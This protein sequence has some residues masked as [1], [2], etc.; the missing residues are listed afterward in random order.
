MDR[1]T[2][3]TVI[4]WYWKGGGILGMIGALPYSLAAPDLLGD[5][6]GR[7]LRALG[8]PSLFVMAFVASFVCYLFG[9]GILTGRARARVAALIYCVVG[10]VVGTLVWART[11]PGDPLVWVNLVGS[12]VFTLAMWFF[13][14]GSPANEYFRTETQ[15]TDGGAA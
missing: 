6:W 11:Y 2:A 8:A 12:V 4:G 13:L 9:K 7:P 15:S 3:V 5:Y 1:P 10:I 14:Y